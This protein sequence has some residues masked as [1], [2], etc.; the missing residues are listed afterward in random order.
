[1]CRKRQHI[2][3]RS[4]NWDKKKLTALSI[5]NHLPDHSRS[6]LP[7]ITHTHT[8]LY[9]MY[10]ECLV[11]GRCVSSRSGDAS[12]MALECWWKSHYCTSSRSSPVC[13][14]RQVVSVVQGGG[15]TAAAAAECQ[16]YYLS[17]RTK[18]VRNV[19][20]WIVQYGT[21]LLTVHFKQ[22]QI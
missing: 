11:G 9:C 5:P 19:Q 2:R 7:T 17:S 21:V 14:V 16:S 1:M 6:S 4:N 22:D 20:G 18:E 3:R 15:N 10:L 12:D 13:L 8:V